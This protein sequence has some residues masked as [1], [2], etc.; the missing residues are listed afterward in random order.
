MGYQEPSIQQI[1]QA[2]QR[3]V[4]AVRTLDELR[5]IMRARKIAGILSDEDLRTFMEV[6]AE[7]ETVLLRLQTKAL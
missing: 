2:E 7:V 4:R 3:L 6:D 1:R 5:S